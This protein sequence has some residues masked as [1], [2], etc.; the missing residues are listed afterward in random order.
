VTRTGECPALF[1]STV[2]GPNLGLNRRVL[3]DAGHPS[4]GAMKPESLQHQHTIRPSKRS[5]LDD[6][7]ISI[8]VP[9]AAR[10]MRPK[11]KSRPQFARYEADF[12]DL[13]QVDS[14]SHSYLPGR[15]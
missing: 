4:R 14:R 2:Y 9:G 5:A 6:C 12:A 15:T 7:N 8:S 10:L 3:T 13:G 11:P 1:T